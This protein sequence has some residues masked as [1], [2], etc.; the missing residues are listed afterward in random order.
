MT[1]DLKADLDKVAKIG[2]SKMTER[3]AKILNQ[4]ERAEEGSPEREA[5][6]ER[7]LA[8]SQAYSIDLAVARAH[9][10]KKERVEQP[11]RRAFKVGEQRRNGRNQQGKNAHFVDLMLAI[12]HANDIE[13]VISGTNAFVYGTGMPSDLD[14]AERLFSILSVQMMTEADTALKNGANKTV[15][16]LPKRVRV[17]IAKDKM[18]WGGYDTKRDIFFDYE[19]ECTNPETGQIDPDQ[20]V[21]DTWGNVYYER[22]RKVRV[23]PTSKLVDVTDD[24]GNVVYE[25]KEV[26]TVDARIWRTNFY[27]GFVNRTRY[28]LREAKKAALKDA[29]VDLADD[30]DSRSLA[31]RDKKKEVRDAYEENEKLVLANTRSKGYTGAEVSKPDYTAH[32][33]GDEAAKRARLGNEKDLDHA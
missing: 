6:M 28:R 29:G 13:C 21:W 4:A 23:P 31:L 19:A 2:S 14:M 10:A 25:M 15:E 3:V 24:D 22:L 32:G 26:S 9:Q 18:A 17:P 1:E 27:A 12:C 11:E 20:E 30:T 7:A 8:L 16:R 33:A 5:F